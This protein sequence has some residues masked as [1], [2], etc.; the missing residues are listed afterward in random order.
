MSRQELADAA[1]SYIFKDRQ[2]EQRVG[3]LDDKYIGKLER[4]VYRWP[5]TAI[6]EALRHALRTR[7]DAELGFY[8][9]RRTSGRVLALRSNNAN[10]RIGVQLPNQAMPREADRED[11]GLHMPE[12]SVWFGMRLA[13]L[14]AMVHSCNGDESDVLQ[15]LLHQE[16]LMFDAMASDEGHTGFELSRRQALMTLAA[17]PLALSAPFAGARFSPDSFLNN[18]GASLTACWHLLRG[19]DLDTVDRLVGGYLLELEAIAQKPSK[20]QPV[21]ARLAS[22]SHR[23]SGIIALHRNHVRARE[24]H[25]NQAVR[26]ADLAQDVSSHVSAL[27][28][29]ASTYFYESNPHRAAQTYER[30]LVFDGDMSP[31]HR[32]RLRAE[33]SVVYGQ[34]GRER[35]TLDAVEQAAELYPAQPERDPSYL[36][37]EF[38]RASL[39]LER[40]LAYVEL[41]KRHRDRRY[42]YKADE[43]FEGI[44][45]A[46]R[47]S[48]P[49]RIRFEITNHRA[50]TAVLLNDLD[51]FEAHL[52]QGVEG[53]LLLA[54]KQREHEVHAAWNLA[55]AR[56][57]GEARLKSAGRQLMLELTA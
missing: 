33:L 22:Q 17:L 16:I 25:C 4:G 19:S 3:G 44:E 40:G 45:H 34:L 56:W 57:P 15:T 41:A 30:A 39:T 28:S 9:L 10:G 24:H 32:S 8:V 49:D 35:E 29:L 36:Y 7:T 53:A 27:I 55:I 48:I 31:L 54:S 6:R 37:A 42:E 47:S 18:C 26:Y 13:R 5:G 20:Y 52:A 14:M 11:G 46:A 1:N 51:A 38:T 2:R 12:W 43:I 23:I 50:A 21:A